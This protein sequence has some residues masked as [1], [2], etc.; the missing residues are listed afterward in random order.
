MIVNKPPFAYT[1]PWRRRKRRRRRKKKN[2]NKKTNKKKKN[3]RKKKLQ[4]TVTL[5]IVHW[6][7]RDRQK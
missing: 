5:K 1:V 4:N 7:N 2:K 3:E 6:Y